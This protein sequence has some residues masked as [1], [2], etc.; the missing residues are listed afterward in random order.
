MM[1]VKEFIKQYISSDNEF[2]KRFTNSIRNF[3]FLHVGISVTACI[4]LTALC[5]DPQSVVDVLVAMMPVYIA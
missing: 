3:M 2:S 5:M 1:T 4:T